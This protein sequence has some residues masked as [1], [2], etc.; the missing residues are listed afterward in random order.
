MVGDLET[1]DRLSKVPCT[2]ASKDIGYL[3]GEDGGVDHDS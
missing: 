1:R 3:T 2:G